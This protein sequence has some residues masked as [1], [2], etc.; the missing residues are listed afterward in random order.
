MSQVRTAYL[1]T[2][3]RCTNGPACVK[4]ANEGHSLIVNGVEYFSPAMNA[5][6]RSWYS[7]YGTYVHLNVYWTGSGKAAFG[8]HSDK[9]TVTILQLSGRKDWRVCARVLPRLDEPGFGEVMPFFNASDEDQ[10]GI[11]DSCQ[12]VDMRAG[13]A[14][15]M[16]AGVCHRYDACNAPASLIGLIYNFA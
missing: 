15:Y 8:Y 1:S 7:F 12:V 11:V 2:P 13:D 16:P 9:T 3:Q 10:Q 14:L 6:A 5:L 4:L